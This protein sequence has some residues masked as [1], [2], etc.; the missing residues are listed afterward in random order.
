MRMMK[1]TKHSLKG[2]FLVCDLSEFRLW[3]EDGS[4]E[5]TEPP[6]KTQ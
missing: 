4:S 3:Y 5:M 2:T 1:V 6:G